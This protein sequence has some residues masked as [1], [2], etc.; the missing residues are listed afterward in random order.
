MPPE[1]VPRPQGPGRVGLPKRQR[2]FHVC[3]PTGSGLEVYHHLPDPPSALAGPGGAPAPRPKCPPHFQ[4]FG[5]DRVRLLA[6]GSGQTRPS[7]P[8]T[9]R[10]QCS[11]QSSRSGCECAVPSAPAPH[12][13]GPARAQ[14]A[15]GGLDPATAAKRQRASGGPEGREEAGNAAKPPGASRNSWGPEER[16]LNLPPAAPA[17]GTPSYSTSHPRPPARPPLWFPIDERGEGRQVVTARGTRARARARGGGQDPLAPESPSARPS[18]RAPRRLQ[19]TAQLRGALS[20][21][22]TDRQTRA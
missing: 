21:H 3:T 12:R 13:R 11:P 15:G 1:K 2:P 22:F 17:R 10:T 4:G 18:H 6:S 7:G 5:T 20:V 9:P 19:A 14:R 16:K 8:L